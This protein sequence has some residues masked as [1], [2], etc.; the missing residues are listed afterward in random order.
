MSKVKGYIYLLQE[1]EFI[2][3][4]TPVYKIG[5]TGHHPNQRLSK[6]PK[7]SE[8]HVVVGVD[9]HLLAESRLLKK[10]RGMFIR[11]EDIG[12]EY[13][14]GDLFKMKEIIVKYS[15]GNF[16][17][18]E[19][20]IEVK[21]EPTKEDSMTTLTDLRNECQKIGLPVSGTKEQL[22]TKI[23]LY[24]TIKDLPDKSLTSM[25]KALNI[26]LTK[27]GKLAKLEYIK[28]MSKIKK[29]E[30][31]EEIEQASLADPKGPS[32]KGEDLEGRIKVLESIV[33]KLISRVEI[34]EAKTPIKPPE[35]E[36]AS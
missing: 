20:D 1:R 9:D 35:K 19:V 12:A 8:L 14:E 30:T 34:L 36:N 15:L 17:N 25:A 3:L 21:V 23:E 22:Q 32:E 11:R 18:E 6:Y 13:F 10:F 7:D 27:T 33:E 26:K 24:N 16:E 5:R 28:K 2:S 29:G 31:K 4:R